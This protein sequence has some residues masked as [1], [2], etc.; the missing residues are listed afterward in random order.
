MVRLNEKPFC[1]EKEQ[2]LWVYQNL[3]E[4]T[5][6]EKI[7][8][9]LCPQLTSFQEEVVSYYTQTLHVG[10]CMIRPFAME[11]IADNM[12]KMQKQSKIPLLVAANLESGGNGAILEGTMFAN[13]MGCAASNK[14]ENG[15][16]LGKV[17][18]AEA[19]SVG[20]NWAFAPIVDIDYNYHNPITNVR[21]FGSNPVNVL[22]Y[23]REYIRAA[24]EEQVVP[25]IKHFPGDG[26]DER[27]QHLLVSVNDKSYSE[28]RKSYGYIYQS[29]I[30][31]GAP[32]VMA[33]HIAAPNVADGMINC[34]DE[35]R[36]LPASQSKILLTNLLREQM[37][38]NGLIITDS[39]LMVG[40][41]QKMPRKKAI[42]YSIEC[43]ADMIL[44]NRSIEED[45]QYLHDG[46][47]EGILSMERLNE[48]VTRVL[49]LKAS[50]N[51]MSGKV[52]KRPELQKEIQSEQTRLWVKECADESVTLVKDVSQNL[53]LSP[54]KTKRIYLNVIEN[55]VTNNSDFAKNMKKRFSDEGFQVTLR[56]RKYS[57]DSK[58][59]NLFN[60]TPAVNKALEETMCSTS[61]FVNQYDMAIIVINIQT[62]SNETV[63]RV[64]WNVLFGMGNDLPW[65][66]GEMPLLVI[67]TNNPYHLLDVPMAHTYINTYS[68]NDET[69]DAL[70]EKI[71]GRSEFKGVSPVDAFCG[72]GDTRV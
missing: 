40:Y 6:E 35:E 36:Y 64:K 33:G 7:G 62:A 17:S 13:P 47:K 65:Y 57:F 51:L 61:D 54:E 52:G 43:G 16:R 69:I 5:L 26:T 29:L 19:A 63:A 34:S 70:F 8:Q 3:E 56:K 42:P 45:I 58:K 11:E 44:F 71:M 38:F 68:A 37:G 32:S 41:M 67:S 12:V 10:A 27:D 50:I 23:A 55:D 1:L 30:D 2:E 21:T 20:V 28:W 31:E 9:I 15:Y 22:Q 14:V 66:S 59:I 46:I 49:A 53:P 60:I 25:T 39:T 72:R 18:C 4:M 24:K 48:A